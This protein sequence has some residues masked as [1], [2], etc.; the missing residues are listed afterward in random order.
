M[1]GERTSSGGEQSGPSTR[2]VATATIQVALMEPT[3]QH[4]SDA[5]AARLAQC[6]RPRGGRAGVSS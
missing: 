2:P 3:H 4:V 5:S 1:P 6:R